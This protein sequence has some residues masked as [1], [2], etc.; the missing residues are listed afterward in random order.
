MDAISLINKYYADNEPLRELLLLHSRQVTQR[1][2][3]IA[4]RHPELPIDCEF[5]E[6]A[7]MLHDIGIFLTDAPGIHCHGT[8]PY[9]LHGRLGAE[10]MRQEGLERVARVCERHTGTGLTP[11][12]IARQNLPLPPGDYRPETLEEQ[13][14]CYA[15]KF[16]SKSHPE[17]VRSIADTARSLEKFGAEGVAV[18][19]GWAKLFD[20][21][22]PCAS[23]ASS[24]AS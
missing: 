13:L 15:D 14:I 23:S 3:D 2:L 24:S 9:L 19:L 8:Q 4:C 10:L 12:V 17:R 1:A 7:A 5:V 20:N 11:E 22:T 18:F 16:F 6:Q 21:Y